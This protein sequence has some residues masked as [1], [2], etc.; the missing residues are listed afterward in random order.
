MRRLRAVSDQGD[1]DLTELSSLM[2]R[3]VADTN[4]T[5]IEVIPPKCSPALRWTL[6]GG[7]GAKIG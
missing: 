1:N 5:V 3:S 7:G 6:I 4:W 2:P